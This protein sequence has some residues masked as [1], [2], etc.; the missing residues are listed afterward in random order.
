MAVSGFI[1][2]PTLDRSPY[3]PDTEGVGR[4]LIGMAGIVYNA[5]VGAPAYG[6]AGDHVEPGVSI[7]HPDDAVDHAMHYLTCVGNEAF[8]ASGPAIGARGVVTG[9]HARLLVDFAPDVLEQLCVGDRIVIKTE[10]RGMKL[11]DFPGVLVKK[12]G[13]NLIEA[14]GLGR[15]AAGRLQVPVVATIPAHIMGSGAE[16]TP[17]F[18]DQDLMTGDR[19]ALAEHGIDNLKLGDLVAVMDTDHRFGRGF[20]PGGVTI[21]LIMHGDSV[22]TGH[23]PGCQDMLV[24]A[25]GEIE[26]VIDPGANIA[27]MLGMV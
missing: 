18:V 5:R 3:R 27:R 23:G 14:W 21:G 26:P 15:S 24:C 6:W 9:E 22:M 16:L 7:A 10:G 1:S 11:L 8:V 20:K 17:E 4:V 12:A 2:A 13:P 19:A 25:N